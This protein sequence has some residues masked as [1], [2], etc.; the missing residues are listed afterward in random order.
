MAEPVSEKLI[1][2]PDGRRFI[3]VGNPTI[4]YQCLEITAFHDLGQFKR[5]WQ[6]V[7]AAH[8]AG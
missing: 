5:S 6:A 7:A 8:E 3:V 1:S 2:R 4:G